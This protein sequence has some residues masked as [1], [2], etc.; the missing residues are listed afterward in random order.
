MNQEKFLS[1]AQQIGKANKKLSAR[2]V[3]HS[4]SSCSPLTSPHKSSSSL[5]FLRLVC[6]VTQIFP[7]A[8]E[9]RAFFPLLSPPSFEARKKSKAQQQR[10]EY[11]Q[12]SSLGFFP[13]VSSTLDLLECRWKWNWLPEE[14]K[15]FSRV[16]VELK[17]RF[18]A[19]EGNQTVGGKRG[20]LA[21]L[22]ER[23][24]SFFSPD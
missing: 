1:A 4:H 15:T 24:N 17:N 18:S 2:V 3:N 8:H 16:K 20:K 23:L 10:S 12:N 5:H 11:F 6:P 13:S 19:I 9:A 14:F 21:S 22:V 7:S